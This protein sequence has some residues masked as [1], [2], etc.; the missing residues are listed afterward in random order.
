M[1]KITPGETSDLFERIEHFKNEVEDSIR[2]LEKTEIEIRRSNNHKPWGEALGNLNQRIVGA[3]QRLHGE[4]EGFSKKVG[5][6]TVVHFRDAAKLEEQ[7]GNL[8]MSFS[9]WILR[10]QDFLKRSEGE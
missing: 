4:L 8:N 10:Y 2:R 3:Y 1:V 7:S 9:R 5:S 6:G